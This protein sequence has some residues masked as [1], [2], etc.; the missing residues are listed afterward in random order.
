MALSLALVGVYGVVGY[1]V[2]R[3]RREI[4]V[5]MALGATPWQVVRPLLAE[6]GGIVVLG[7]LAGM[8]AALPA[9]RLL[10]TMLYGI[11]PT[12]AAT[13]ALVMLLVAVVAVFASVLPASRALRVDPVTALRQD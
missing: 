6:H 4:G 10:G 11:P 13:Y 3:R 8:A 2:V 9:T 7:L 1:S 12:D 5:R